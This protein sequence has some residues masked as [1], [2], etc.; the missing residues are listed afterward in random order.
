M[1]F[2]SRQQDRNQLNGSISYRTVAK[3]RGL[4]QGDPISC[5]LY[6]FTLE[7]LLRFILQD[8]SYQGYSF[9]NH[10]LS[11]HSLPNIKH[12]SYADD[13]LVFLRDHADLCLKY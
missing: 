13:M 10:Q 12:L 4:K 11:S 5:I 2:V 7:P 6:N 8:A 1:L 3:R 9:V